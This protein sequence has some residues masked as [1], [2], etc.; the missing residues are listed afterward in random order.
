MT[1]KTLEVYATSVRE[2]CDW[3]ALSAGSNVGALDR[4]LVGF[5]NR[6]DHRAWKG[7]KL[8]ASVPF[9]FPIFSQLDGWWVCHE[10]DPRTV[11]LGVQTT[12]KPETVFELRRLVEERERE[13]GGIRRG[14]V[15][16][17]G[18]GGG[19]GG[20]VWRGVSGCGGWKWW[21]LGSGRG[22]EGAEVDVM[23]Q[24]LSFECRPR[25]VWSRAVSS[26]GENVLGFFQP[27]DVARGDT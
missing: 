22:R 19:S 11:H 5:M 7:D 9:F 17:S 1:R 10:G 16:W 27:G 21:W 12:L 26:V 13:G 6:E 4:P 15:E 3:S 18:G 24:R 25:W 20:V 14:G 2:S 23:R 8:L